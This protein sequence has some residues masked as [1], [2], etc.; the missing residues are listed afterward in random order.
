MRS[1]RTR[2][3]CIALLAGMV[4]AGC[5]SG[6]RASSDVVTPDQAKAVALAHVQARY[7]TD[8]MKD[9]VGELREIDRASLVARPL[10]S[11]EPT[12]PPLAHD[13]RV[14]VPHQ[15]GYPASFLGY[16]ALVLNGTVASGILYVFVK[17]SATSHWTTSFKA[18]LVTPT[19]P[20]VATDSS[21]W[22]QVIP[23]SRF[24]A[25][26]VSPDQVGADYGAYL[27]AGNS[28][29]AHEFAPGQVT[30][31]AVDGMNT[32]IR[33]AA[34]S[35]SVTVSF[36][37]KPTGDPVFAYLL[38]N[39]GALVLSSLLGTIDNLATKDPMTVTADGKGVI[40]PPPGKYSRV[41]TDQAYL[42]AFVVP[43]KGSSDKVTVIGAVNGPIQS[44]GTKA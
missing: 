14:W 20:D 24:D 18:T 21:G 4:L 26:R 12:E 16:D 39:G 11:P 37:F 19:A 29:D 30:S 13:V 3:G 23:P 17:P 27:A 1:L 33:Q 38:N 41:T 15:S 43:P 25:F 32:Q 36:T 40:G 9:D 31:Q 6:A 34:R 22:A 42:V 8:M 44:I 5:G 10:P 2:A 7:V 28:T 35:S